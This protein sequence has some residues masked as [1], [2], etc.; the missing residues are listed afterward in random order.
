ME[1][2][3][4]GKEEVTF[5]ADFG[6]LTEKD[7]DESSLLAEEFFQMQNKPKEIPASV[8]NKRFI[9]KKIPECDNIIR[10]NGRAIGFTFIVPCNVGIMERFLSNK[11]T[12][13]ELFDE[14][15]N[16]ITYDNFDAIYLC[17][18]FIKKKYRGRGLAIQ[19][20]IKSINKIIGGR[21]IKP[22]LFSW[23]QTIEGGKSVKRTAQELGFHLKLKK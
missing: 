23:P 21:K 11:I 17:S 22:I 16:K 10:C 7:I 2:N 12:E 3:N 1:K 20:R 6:R 19:G 15:K 5:S 9:L 14:C 4:K 13:R 18:S 8:E